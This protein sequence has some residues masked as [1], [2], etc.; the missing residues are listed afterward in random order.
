MFV[1]FFV[2]WF[3]F[4]FKKKTAYEM[5]ISD[6]SSDVCSSDLGPG[7]AARIDFVVD[8][9]GSPPNGN[10]GT[11][12]NQNHAFDSHYNANGASALFTNITNSS[13]VRL[14]ARDDI[15]TDNDIGDGVKDT[16]TK[17]AISFNN[18]TLSVTA[19]GT[20]NV[21]GQNFTVTFANDE[22]TVAG[23]VANTVVA[24]FTADGYNKIGRA[25]L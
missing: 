7:E 24:G 15:D 9:T 25:N 6:W 8:L 3:F 17:V 1:L 10:Y 22:A 13:S 20:Y 23:V 18:A 16:I 11:L 4:F 2:F 12:A 21:G 5:R 19:N 14:V